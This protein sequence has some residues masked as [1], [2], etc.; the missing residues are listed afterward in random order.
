LEYVFLSPYFHIGDKMTGTLINCAAVIIGG[1]IGFIFKKGINKSYEKSINYA[2]GIGVLI[3]GI[4]GIIASMFSVGD[5]G[6]ITSSGE[7]LLIISLVIGTFIGELLHIDDHLNGLSEK[8]EKKLNITS[9]ALGFVNS[10][11][12][13]CIGAMAIIGAINDGLTGDS[14]VLIIKST[15]DFVSAIILSSTLG[16]GVIFSFIPL[17][18]YQCGISLLAGILNSILQG[19][20]LT[21]VCTAGYAIIICIGINFIFP[22][23]IKTANMLPAIIIPVVYS[24]IKLLFSVIIK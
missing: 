1:L 14:S 9:F 20:L 13:F 4:N 6:K 10:T 22:V 16:I 21:Q 15:L 11:L 3:I 23:K 7:L 8:I 2:L 19:E 24:G 12:L 18:L 17:F 5:N